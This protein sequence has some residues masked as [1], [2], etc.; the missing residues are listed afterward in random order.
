MIKWLKNIFVK[1]EYVYLPPSE[2]GYRLRQGETVEFG[3][4]VNIF[5]GRIVMLTNNGEDDIYIYREQKI[6][7]IDD[8]N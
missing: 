3:V 8:E 1:K 2:Y 5:D 6:K 4:D 7:E